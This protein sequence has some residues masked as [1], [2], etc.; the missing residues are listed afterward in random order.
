MGKWNAATET[1]NGIS[2]N[3]WETFRSLEDF[4]KKLA[5]HLT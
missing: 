2:M 1:T 4:Y 5:K 3:D